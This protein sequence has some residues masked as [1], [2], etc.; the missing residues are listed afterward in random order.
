[1]TA[2]VISAV[3]AIETLWEALTPPDR[4]TVSYH[5]VDTGTAL[6]GNAGDRGFVFDPPVRNAPVAEAGA[7]AS[8]VEWSI[9]VRIRLNRS[10]RDIRSL[11]N[12]V[13]NEGNLL[14]RAIEKEPNWPAGV[15]DVSTGNIIPEV[16]MGGNVELVTEI[17]ILTEE[18]D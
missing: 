3:D 9:Q 2:T 4:T 10:G 1:M 17:T 7:P 18:T 8:Q 14:A 5:R 11:H 16:V 13:A 15:L 12:A 6:E